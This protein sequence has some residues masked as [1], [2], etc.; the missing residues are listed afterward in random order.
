M[1]FN[2]MYLIIATAFIFGLWTYDNALNLN[3]YSIFILF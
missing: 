1:K 2:L 3:L